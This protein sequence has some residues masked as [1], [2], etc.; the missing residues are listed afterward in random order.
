MDSKQNSAL[1]FSQAASVTSSTGTPTKY[2]L[3]AVFLETS[4]KYIFGIYI[5]IESI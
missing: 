1:L 5:N 2:S 3:D 4:E